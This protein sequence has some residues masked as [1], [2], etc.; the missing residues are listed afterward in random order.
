MRTDGSIEK[1]LVLAAIGVT[2]TGQKLVLGFQAGDKESAPTWRE[3][4]K[5]LKER[6]L[7]GSK[8]VLSVMDGLP[9]LEKIFKKEFPK[10][11]VHR[12]LAHVARNVLAKEP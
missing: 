2:E 12:C 7:D 10:A 9:G 1:V 11:K 4:L 3:F 6:G 8:M 5:D